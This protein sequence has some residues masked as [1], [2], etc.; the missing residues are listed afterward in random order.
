MVPVSEHVPGVCMRPKAFPHLRERGVERLLRR[1][2]LGVRLLQLSLQR[3]HLTLQLG[4]GSLLWVQRLHHLLVL[5]FDKPPIRR[6]HLLATTQS[7]QTVR[8]IFL[9]S[10]LSSRRLDVGLET[11]LVRGVSQRQIMFM[12]FDVDK[13]HYKQTTALINPHERVLAL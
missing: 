5:G 13:H 7:G 8:R 9:F 10:C 2:H 3:L 4:E 1:V 6:Y 12:R 11:W